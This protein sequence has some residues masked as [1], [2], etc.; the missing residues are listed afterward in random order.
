MSRELS[1]EA[2]RQQILKV[3]EQQFAVTGFGSTTVASVARAA[4]VSEAMLYRQFGRKQKLFEEVLAHN[5]QD[6]LAALRE[7]F[8]SIPEIPPLQC[9]E[10][11]AQSTILACVD[12]VGNGTVMAWALMELPEFAADVY[13]AEIGVTETLWDSEI[14]TRLAGSPLRTWAAIH[15]LPYAVHVCMAFGFW[16]AT[17]RH[18]PATAQAHARQFVDG[19]MD[20]ARALLSFPLES[21]HTPPSRLP[22]HNVSSR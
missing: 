1:R 5:T 13:R 12:D 8:F 21:F 10:S 19:I 16:L 7:R 11:M 18:N 4:G 22:E 20:I 6:R 17:L 3:A 15:L 9:I 14:A 2:R